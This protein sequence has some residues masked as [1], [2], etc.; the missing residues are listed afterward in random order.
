MF[1]CVL[2]KKKLKSLGFEV[3][4][5]VVNILVSGYVMSFEFI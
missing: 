2:M 1:V 3:I 4:N 5:I